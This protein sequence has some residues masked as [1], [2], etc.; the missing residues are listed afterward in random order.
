M[1]SVY[2][3]YVGFLWSKY[4]K[5]WAFWVL[6]SLK[7]PEKTL[8]VNQNILHFKMNDWMNEQEIF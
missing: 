7:M 6:G 5:L 3:C 8:T 2:A 1:A 4:E